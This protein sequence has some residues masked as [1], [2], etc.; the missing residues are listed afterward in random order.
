MTDEFERIIES[1]IPKHSIQSLLGLSNNQ[2]LAFKGAERWMKKR[3]V[4][5]SKYHEKEKHV[6]FAKDLFMIWDDDNSQT[7]TLDELTEP[8]VALGLSTDKL[9]V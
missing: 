5:D 3:K 4:V 7:L 6:D 8:L 2:F 1:S 9:F